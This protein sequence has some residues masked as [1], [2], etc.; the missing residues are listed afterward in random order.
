M[1][2]IDC[3]KKLNKQDKEVINSLKQL[4][5]KYKIKIGLNCYITDV[6]RY[7]KSKNILIE[8]YER[9]FKENGLEINNVEKIEIVENDNYKT[10]IKNPLDIYLDI[11]ENINERKFIPEI[12]KETIVE[13]PIKTSNY[14]ISFFKKCLNKTLKLFK[15]K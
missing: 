3:T 1:V 8:D 9:F 5:L 7:F 10:M 12:Y 15:Y 2:T 4:F 11:C 13:N 14:K 6:I